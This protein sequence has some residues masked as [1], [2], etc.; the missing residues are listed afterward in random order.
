MKLQLVVSYHN[1][2]IPCTQ[3]VRRKDSMVPS[4]DNVPILCFCMLDPEACT[5]MN[6]LRK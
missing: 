2:Y 6:H 1:K 3:H 5:A 4:L